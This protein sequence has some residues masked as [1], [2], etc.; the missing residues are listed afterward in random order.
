MAKVVIGIAVLMLAVLACGGDK[1][2]DLV[3]FGEEGK[4]AATSGGGVESVQSSK[5]G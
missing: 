1:G 4:T 5:G 2:N 3:F